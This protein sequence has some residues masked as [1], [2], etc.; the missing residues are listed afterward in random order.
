VVS[1]LVRERM[2][3]PSTDMLRETDERMFAARVAW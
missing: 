3:V 2:I 1:G